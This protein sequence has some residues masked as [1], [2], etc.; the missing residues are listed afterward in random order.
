MYTF[1]N[2]GWAPF[3]TRK[4]GKLCMAR[5]W[6]A[7][8][9]DALAVLYTRLAQQFMWPLVR[10]L[11]T[12]VVRT[13][14]TNL[15]RL[16]LAQPDMAL[17]HPL[18]FVLDALLARLQLMLTPTFSKT[19]WDALRRRALDARPAIVALEPVPPALA[20]AVEAAAAAATCHVVSMTAY[21]VTTA[22]A[23]ARRGA[24]VCARLEIVLPEPVGGGGSDGGGDG[25]ACHTT[26]A[27][28]AS[29]GAWHTVW[30]C[31]VWGTVYRLECWDEHGRVPFHVYFDGNAAHA[32]YVPSGELHA[33]D[34]TTGA[35][36]LLRSGGLAYT[37]RGR[38]ADFGLAPCIRHADTAP[39]PRRI[40]RLVC[41]KLLHVVKHEDVGYTVALSPPDDGAAPLLGC[42]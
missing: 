17:R 42:G 38:P 31:A 14:L 19:A 33:R 4:G 7:H 22:A 18:T 23:P 15:W 9:R 30:P 10:L 34:D 16:C 39:A 8:G 32:M 5:V 1:I 24:L 2:A 6:S 26:A 20:A 41:D 28:A 11:H 13:Q 29:A 21:A 3:R 25:S 40:T 35:A 37:I 27:P 36:Q 12:S